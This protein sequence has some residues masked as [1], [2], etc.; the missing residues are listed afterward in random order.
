MNQMTLQEFEKLE[1]T[2]KR[3]WEQAVNR[4]IDSNKRIDRDAILRYK[5][6]MDI[7]KEIK[8]KLVW[9]TSLKGN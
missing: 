6:K 7:L 4:F 5:A 9:T 2:N 8:E 1:E 3:C